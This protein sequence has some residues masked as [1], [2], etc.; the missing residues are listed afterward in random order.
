ME[1]PLRSG[2]QG[3]QGCGETSCSALKPYSV[4]L[5]SESTPPTTAASQRPDWIRRLALAKTLALEEQAVE[6]TKAG[7]PRSR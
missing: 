5:H 7:P 4:M 6:M 2:S 1:M 3:R